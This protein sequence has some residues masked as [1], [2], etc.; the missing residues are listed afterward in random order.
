MLLQNELYWASIKFQNLE[1]RDC[2][3][4]DIGKHM[5]YV[6]KDWM[7]QTTEQFS[8]AVI[9]CREHVSH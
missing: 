5:M 1:V 3:N 2:K 7:S 8:S 4:S 6:K 9:A